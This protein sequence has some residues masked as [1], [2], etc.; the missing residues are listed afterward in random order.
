MSTKKATSGIKPKSSAR[1][2]KTIS[3]YDLAQAKKNVSGRALAQQNKSR[4]SKATEETLKT[5]EKISGRKLTI[6]SM[7]W[8][9]RECDEISQTAF[10]K[11]L[12]ISR[13]Y[14]CDVEHDRKS[15]S[16]KMAAQFADILGYSK[17]QFVRLAFQ[18]ELN[19]YNLHL[20]V[21][22]HE[23]PRRAA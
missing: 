11:M 2:E 18:A 13:Q 23:D 16:A 6:G 14:L 20:Q 12:G 19:R 3:A 1:T 17:S 5:L 15:I 10:A 7:L 4:L 22:I 21:E 8:S 9:I